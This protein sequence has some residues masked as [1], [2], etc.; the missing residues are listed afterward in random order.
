[1]PALGEPLA[2]QRE[3]PEG[4]EQRDAGD[5]GRQHDGQ[6][7]QRLEHGVTREA[8]A[9]QQIGQRRAGDQRDA[10]RPERRHDAELDRRGNVLAR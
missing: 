1:M 8:A 7:E 9:R 6:I 10:E 4:E 2:D 5:G 3:A